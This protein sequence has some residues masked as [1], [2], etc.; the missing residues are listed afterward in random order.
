MCQVRAFKHIDVNT[1]ITNIR[2]A[3]LKIESLLTESGVSRVRF[4]IWM[5]H[6]IAIPN[7]ETSYYYGSLLKQLGMRLLAT[8]LKLEK[9]AGVYLLLFYVD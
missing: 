8:N 5:T 2:A 4:V 1:Q 3:M 9:T 7:I 6:I